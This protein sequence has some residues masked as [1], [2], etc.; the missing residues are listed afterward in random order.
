MSE[1]INNKWRLYQK[2]LISA[3]S[4]HLQEKIDGDE[5]KEVFR[6]NKPLLIRWSTDWDMDIKSAWWYVI[7]DEFRGF[8][9]LKSKMRNQVRKGLK[10]CRVEKISKEFL[11]ENGYEIYRQAMSSYKTYLKPENIEQFKNRILQTDETNYDFWGVFHIEDNKLIAFAQNQLN[12]QC[13]DYSIIKLD[14][15]YLKHYPSYALIFKMNEFYLSNDNIKYVFDGTRS[16]GHE[17]NIQDFL[18]SKFNFRKCYCKLN[19]YYAARL[20]WAV[21][22]L[23]P[24]RKALRNMKPNLINK[25]YIL[26]KQEEIRRSFYG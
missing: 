24:L 10:N 13:V 12:E 8:D 9:E 26:L 11:T 15:A 25:L 17:T 7:K 21:F 6:L 22:I 18:I 20:K 19:I 3:V 2:M 1:I 23:Y 16:I 14:P 5:I 4:P